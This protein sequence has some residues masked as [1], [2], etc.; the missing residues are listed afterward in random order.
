MKKI[1]RIKRDAE[2]Q[3]LLTEG[4]SVPVIARTSGLTERTIYSRKSARHKQEVAADPLL[5]ELAEL[6]ARFPVPPLPPIA[7]VLDVLEQARF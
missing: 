5:A 4:W 7:G 2:V 6:E 3:K 1:D